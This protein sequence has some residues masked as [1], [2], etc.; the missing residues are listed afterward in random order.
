MPESSRAEVFNR[1]RSQL[2][3]TM[4]RYAGRNMK[5]FL[6]LDS[7]A[8]ED[9]ALPA[10]TKELL[11]LATSTVLRCDDCIMFH[12]LHCRELGVTSAELEECFNVAL[13][14]GGSITIPHIRRALAAWDEQEQQA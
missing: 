10:K 9:G 6:T 4:Q 8:Y 12:L 14:V 7:Q 11:G 1:Q 5:R 13:V 3:E 2:M